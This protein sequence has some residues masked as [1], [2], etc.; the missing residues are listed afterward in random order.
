MLFLTLEKIQMVKNHSLSDSHHPLKKI[1]PV[2]FP[3]PHYRRDL[4]LYPL[5]LFGQPCF[6]SSKHEEIIFLH[7][8]FMFMPYFVG[9]IVSKK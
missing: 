2:K 7:Q 5:M 8:F 6:Y 1:P 3:I 9:A 4:L